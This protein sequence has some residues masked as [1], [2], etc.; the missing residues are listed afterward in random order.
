MY[1]GKLLK[2]SLAGLLASKTISWSIISIE[3]SGL[4]LGWGKSSFSTYFIIWFLQ[5]NWIW[6]CISLSC[7]DQLSFIFSNLICSSFTLSSFTLAIS[8]FK[9]SCSVFVDSTDFLKFSF[10]TSSSFF[11]NIFSFLRLFLSCSVLESFSLRV[12]FSVFT[13]SKALVL[14]LAISIFCCC[15]FAS[16]SLLASDFS[17][18]KILFL[19]S[20]K[21]SSVTDS[22]LK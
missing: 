14:A 1:L 17:N 20:S 19:S 11:R 3:L 22:F 16:V 6:F 18:S 13:C 4:F 7:S 15:C 9:L 10:L 2:S 5:I 21:L 12:V 8:V